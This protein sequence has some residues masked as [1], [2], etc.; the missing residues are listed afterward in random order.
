MKDGKIVSYIDG[1]DEWYGNW[2]RYVNC[3][4]SNK[5]ENLVSFQYHGEIYYRVYK[6]ILPGT[7][8]LIWYGDEYAK[9]LGIPASCEGISIE[10]DPGMI[11]AL[12]SIIFFH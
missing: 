3:S 4:R 1:K 11:A 8:L 12:I 6:D 10:M 2:M 5:E 7:E 9:E